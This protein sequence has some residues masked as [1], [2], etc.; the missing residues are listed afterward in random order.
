MVGEN[1]A[2]TSSLVKVLSARTNPTKARSRSTA[3]R[4]RAAPM[5]RSMQAWPCSTRNSRSST[6]NRVCRRDLVRHSGY[7]AREFARS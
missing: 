3:G 1:G 7:F 6:G 4:W 5:R 2:G